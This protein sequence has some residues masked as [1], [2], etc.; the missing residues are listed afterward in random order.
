MKGYSKGSKGKVAK[1]AS[2]GAVKRSPEGLDKK[3]TPPLTKSTKLMGKGA[4]RKLKGV[5]KAKPAKGK[6]GWKP[7]SLEGKFF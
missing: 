5:D 2:P 4:S 6:E 1:A 7:K 3:T